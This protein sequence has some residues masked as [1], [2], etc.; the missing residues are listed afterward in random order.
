MKTRDQEIDEISPLND[1]LSV[2][3]DVMKTLRFWDLS[4]VIR[5]AVSEMEYRAR[6]HFYEEVPKGEER[7]E[8]EVLAI[9]EVV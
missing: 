7:R 1:K 6:N 8:D 5:L 4:K 2:I 9:K 3:W